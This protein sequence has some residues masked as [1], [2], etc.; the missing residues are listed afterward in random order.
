MQEPAAT[1]PVI[2]VTAGFLGE[3]VVHRDLHWTSVFFLDILE[4]WVQADALLALENHGESYFKSVV[5]FRKQVVQMT[6]Y[7]KAVCCFVVDFLVFF[8][9]V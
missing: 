5:F 1:W 7:N 4:Y 6:I 8:V 2:A 3:V 9:Q